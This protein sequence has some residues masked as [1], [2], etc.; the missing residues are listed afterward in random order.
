VLGPE[1]KA[2][3]AVGFA[4]WERVEERVV[5]LVGEGTDA[6]RPNGERKASLVGKITR[7]SEAWA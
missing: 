7:G 1:G 5:E 4:N 3:G 6:C 2:E